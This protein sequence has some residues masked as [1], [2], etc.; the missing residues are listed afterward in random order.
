MNRSAYLTTGLAIKAL[1]LLSKADVAL[2]GQENIPQGSTIFVVNHFTRL[3][4][5]LLPYYIY[6]LTE[7]PVWSLAASDLFKGGLAR[8]FDLVGVVSTKDPQRDELIVRTLLTGEANWI[9]FPEGS[10]IKTKK[11]MDRG[12]YMI[13]DPKGMRQPHTGAA[14]LALRAE[15]SRRYLLARAEVS[16]EGCRAMLD[17]LDIDS[18]AS[19]Q[20]AGTSIVPVNLTY[21]PIRA[22]ENIAS[23]LASRLVGD[24][25]E[26]LVEE[27]MTE[28][29]ML[30]SG[31]DLDIRFGKPIAMDRF[32]RAPIFRKELQKQ[33][34]THFFTSPA[35]QALTRKTAQDIMQ[36]YMHDIYSM[37]TVNHEHLF[38]SFLRLY[39]FARIKEADLRR[40]VFYA[41][42]LLEDGAGGGYNLHKSLSSDQ[43]HLV[44][45][46][47]YH[48]VDNFLRCALETG[49]LHREGAVLVQDRSKLSGPLS[50]HRGRIDNPLEIVANEVEPLTRLRRLLLSLAW[51]PN[52]LLRINLARYLLKKETKRYVSDCRIHAPERQGKGSGRPFLLPSWPGRP[53]VVLIHSYLAEPEEVRLLARFLNRRGLWVYAPRLPGHGTSPEDLAK[54]SHREWLEA[55]ER[56]FAL[57]SCLCPRVVLGG[58]SVGASLAFDLAARVKEVA[59]V[60]AVCPPL[61]LQDFSSRFMPTDDVWDRLLRRMKKSSDQQQFLQFA[62]DNSHINYNRNP[63]SGIR[64]VGLLLAGL[65]DNAAAITQ[66]VLIVQAENDPVVNPKGSQR[67]YSLLGSKQ[68]EYS[69][70][71]SD[72]HILVNGEG[73]GRVCHAIWEY[74]ADIL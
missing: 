60:F 36:Q 41:A 37:T 71:H 32:L 52:I 19:I 6:T 17:F 46:D 27:I 5:L 73:A 21:Y 12:R 7:T 25:P 62:S 56:G 50:M 9:I 10:M 3:E 51:Q 64:E 26:R 45:D 49:V 63:I 53:G 18:L 54:R 30:L 58:V 11:I 1:S 67:L 39:P 47:R 15:L 72:R 29:T 22:R 69:M 42:T 44:T 4:T 68:K 13:T 40:R 61:R 28:G 57:L 20:Q 74:L 33:D 48:K 8:F 38:V 31:V 43:A 55:V 35:V 66:P 34:A 59:A 14:S 70:L 65:E 24:L 16:E 2:H 23:N